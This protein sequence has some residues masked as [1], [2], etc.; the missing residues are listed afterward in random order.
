MSL[1][2]KPSPATSHPGFQRSTT[3][4][5]TAGQHHFRE[6]ERNQDTRD[7]SLPRRGGQEARPIVSVIVLSAWC[8]LP[9]QHSNRNFRVLPRA[10]HRSRL[11]A[12]IWRPKLVSLQGCLPCWQL[13]LLRRK[14]PTGLAKGLCRD[15][16]PQRGGACHLGRLEMKPGRDAMSRIAEQAFSLG[17]EIHFEAPMWRHLPGP[18]KSSVGSLE[19]AIMIGFAPSA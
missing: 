14:G 2:Y 4:A 16:C 17:A 8:R 15:S 1:S 3:C 9:L 7:R 6:G 13:A 11:Q 18:V 12:R 10:T 19:S 5:P